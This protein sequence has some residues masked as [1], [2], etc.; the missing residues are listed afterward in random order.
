MLILQICT[1]IIM[2][3]NILKN[4]NKNKKLKKKKKKKKKIMRFP[5]F[6]PGYI[7]SKSTKISTTL[8]WQMQITDKNNQYMLKL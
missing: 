2:T 6:D 5:R 8:W 1:V 3:K 4:N 7:G